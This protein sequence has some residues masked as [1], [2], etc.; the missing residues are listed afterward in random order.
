M[1]SRFRRCRLRRRCR[2]SSDSF[3]PFFF[4]S[5]SISLFPSSF[6]TH[7]PRAPG[8]V[9]RC[10]APQL[11]VLGGLQDQ[12]SS[13][14][15]VVV[16]AAT[17]LVLLG[18]GDRGRG[19]GRRRNEVELDSRDGRGRGERVLVMSSTGDEILF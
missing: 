7:D 5:F 19:G 6:D 10:R 8:V 12:R 1:L 15:A 14:V 4:I 3:A 17:L 18:R 9:D 2:S 13:P 16:V 11:L